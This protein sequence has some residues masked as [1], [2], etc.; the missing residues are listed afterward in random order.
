M[1]PLGRNK[2]C[3]PI[4]ITFHANLRWY[5]HSI[6]GLRR[7]LGSQQDNQIAMGVARD[8]HH[9]STTNRG[10]QS[11]ESTVF[12]PLGGYVCSLGSPLPQLERAVWE[13][14]ERRDRLDEAERRVRR[15]EMELKSPRR[16]MGRGR[17]SA[18]SK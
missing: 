14:D 9:Q 13:A 8:G 18:L 3:K 6:C 17:G 2:A 15:L 7:L 11:S 1:I 4:V 12:T 16:K 10:W 5:V